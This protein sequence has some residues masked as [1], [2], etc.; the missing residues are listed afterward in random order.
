[1]S[2]VLHPKSI[3]SHD[4]ELNASEA[5]QTAHV[6]LPNPLRSVRFLVCRDVAPIFAIT[7]VFYMIH[8]CVQT[9]VA[10]FFQAQY[11]LEDAAV[12]AC[13][14]SIGFGVVLG[15]YLNGRLLDGSYSR[16]AKE[17]GITVDRVKGDDRSKF[18][19]EKA[20]L[21]SMVH[22]QVTH[23]AVLVSYG[24]MMKQQV[25][26]S[27]PLVLQFFLG[28]LETST[29]RTCNNLLV[30]TLQDHLSAAAAT[31]NIVRCGMSA[32]GI[33]A[34]EPLMNAIGAHWFLGLLALLGVTVGLGCPALVTRK[35]MD[36]RVARYQKS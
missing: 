30:D 15:G 32:A 8:Y 29:V 3:K 13:Y 14:P 2:F 33:A 18:P 5:P 28:F 25:H 26:I 22:L 34:M 23:F 10:T 31:G 35:G 1:V 16:T 6:R 21:R 11:G 7:G 17:Q 27:G 19:I 24:W 12:G 36:W 20:R 9:S 4:V